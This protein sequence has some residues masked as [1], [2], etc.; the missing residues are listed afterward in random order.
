M[1][2]SHFAV[3]ITS[4]PYIHKIFFQ[5]RDFAR[6]IETGGS[7]VAACQRPVEISGIIADEEGLAGILIF[8]GR[9]SEFNI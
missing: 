7:L 8:R 5:P 4:I 2:H 1:Q 6:V 9:A 3:G